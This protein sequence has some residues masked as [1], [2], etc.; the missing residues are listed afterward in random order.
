MTW[1]ILQF[2]KPFL[3]AVWKVEQENKGKQGIRWEVWHGQVK[4]DVV[5]SVALEVETGG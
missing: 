5:L 2:W 4:G 1:S 3:P